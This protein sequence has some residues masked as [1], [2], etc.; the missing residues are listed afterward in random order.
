MKLRSLQCPL[1]VVIVLTSC[2][3]NPGDGRESPGDKREWS[4][5][6]TLE[7]ETRKEH[8]DQI[9]FRAVDNYE[10]MPVPRE[11]DSRLIWVMLNPS[12]PPFYKQMPEGNFWLDPEQLRTLLARQ[13]ITST[14]QEALRSH[15]KPR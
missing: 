11:A 5:L 14:V 2:G 13:A 6:Q 7:L 10:L 1:F 4:I 8:A 3:G 12:H 15:V 9:Q